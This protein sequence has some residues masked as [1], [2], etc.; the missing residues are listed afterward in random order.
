MSK[1][2]ERLE[3]EHEITFE[4]LIANGWHQD[5]D[6][7]WWRDG[8]ELDFASNILWVRKDYGIH[9]VDS[10]KRL[11]ECMADIDDIDNLKIISR[12]YMTEF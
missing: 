12:S 11:N 8:I 10:I 7:Y 9:G 2:S 4:T 5:E 6:L 1:L 3:R